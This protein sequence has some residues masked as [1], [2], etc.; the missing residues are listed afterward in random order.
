M[1][2]KIK[3]LLI[4]YLIKDNMKA[5]PWVFTIIIIIIIYIYVYIHLN[6]FDKKLIL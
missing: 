5:T 2:K 6:K 4:K 1:Y 3:C